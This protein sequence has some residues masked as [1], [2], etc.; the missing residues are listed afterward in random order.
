MPITQLP[1][2]DPASVYQPVVYKSQFS[3]AAPESVAYIE[4]NVLYNGTSI[5]IDTKS[6]DEVVGTTSFFEIDIS[7]FLQRFL[8]PNRDKSSMFGD[9]SG[10][11]VDNNPDAFG[12]IQVQLKY[13]IEDEFGIIGDPTFTENSLIQ[14]ASIAKRQNGELRSLDQFI[15]P[16]IKF[17]TKRPEYKTSEGCASFL[18][19]YNNQPTLNGFR[20][21]ALDS[22]GAVINTHY[23][24]FGTYQTVEQMTVGVGYENIDQSLATDWLNGDDK[25]ILSAAD[26]Y[27]IDFGEITADIS[28]I[29]SAYTPLTEQVLYEIDNICGKKLKLLWLNDLGGVDEYALPFVNL[30]AVVNSDTFE[31]PLA[32]DAGSAT[33]HAQYDYGRLRNNITA[34]RKYTIETQVKPSVAKWLREL[35]TSAEIY[36]VNPDDATELWRVFP[37]PNTYTERVGFGLVPISFDLN[38]SQDYVVHRV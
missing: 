16:Q 24:T 10:L 1:Q 14:K 38:L 36:L 17:L 9:L 28:G 12:D 32:W 33:P 2:Y 27:L 5:A 13:A 26:S 21:I 31:K 23:S 37:D 15:T 18:S 22:S 29:V 25:P 4:I 30:A 35:L 6:P 7:A 11:F 20:L 19:F 3:I 34:Q 8:A